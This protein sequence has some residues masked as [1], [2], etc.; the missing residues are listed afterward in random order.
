MFKDAVET[1]GKE[2]QSMM[3]LEEMAELQKEVC[4]SLRGN[5]NHDEIVEEIADVLIMIEQLKI[6]HDV[7]YRELNE[8]FNFKINRLKERLKQVI[9]RA[10]IVGRLVRDPVLRKTTSG[11]SVTSFTVAVDRKF[12][13]EGQP[14][15]ILFSVLHGTKLQITL[16]ST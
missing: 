9:N 15:R 1:Y 7:K 8:M 4:K 2:N 5:N 11:A 16:L 13:A 3:V 12:K 6:M 14:M 10:V